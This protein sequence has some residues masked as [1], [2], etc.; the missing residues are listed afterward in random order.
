MCLFTFC[1]LKSSRKI[2]N[3]TTKVAA[4]M[5][6]HLNMGKGVGKEVSTFKKQ[7]SVD[8]MR[9]HLSKYTLDAGAL[10]ERL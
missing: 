3:L 4:V 5:K 2:A 9:N 7:A 6:E 10:C 1:H 8:I